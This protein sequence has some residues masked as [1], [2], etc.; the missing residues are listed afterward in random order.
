MVPRTRQGLGPG[1]PAKPR[2]CKKTFVYV[3]EERELT[4]RRMLRERGWPEDKTHLT[5]LARELL[6]KTLITI[7]RLYQSQKGA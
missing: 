5:R 7:E 4:L 3:T 1:R 6:N 2:I